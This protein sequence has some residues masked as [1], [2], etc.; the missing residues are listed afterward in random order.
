[1]KNESLIAT[2]F[3]IL[4]SITL[5]YFFEPSLHSFWGVTFFGIK[6]SVAIW[7]VPISSGLVTATV[8]TLLLRRSDWK[9]KWVRTGILGGL[10]SFLIYAFIHVVLAVLSGMPSDMAPSLLLLIIVFGGVYFLPLSLVLGI[11]ALLSAKT[12]IQRK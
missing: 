5:V 4:T 6:Y 2:L 11:I 7:A 9:E 10:A 8:F 12:F 1:M 3:A